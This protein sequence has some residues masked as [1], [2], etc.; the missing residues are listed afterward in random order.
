MAVRDFFRLDDD[1]PF[2]GRHMLALVLAFF[3]TVIAVNVV[4]A[5]AA[6][7]SFPGLVVKNSYVASQNYNALLQSARAQADS[8]WTLELGAPGGL[9]AAR[10]VSGDGALSRDLEVTAIAG[11][12]STTRYDRTIEFAETAG[13][14]RAVDALQPGLWEIDVEARHRGELVFREVRRLT[15]PPAEPD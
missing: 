13:G 2:T 7:G 4:M 9:L 8:G 15:V 12:P 3:G 1:H 11:R 14:Y 10:F 6:T 5:V